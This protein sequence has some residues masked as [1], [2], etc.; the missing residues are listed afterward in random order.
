MLYRKTAHNADSGK[1]ALRQG[2]QEGRDNA[3]LTLEANQKR[4]T[5]DYRGMMLY[6]LLWRQG[7]ITRPDVTEQRQT[8]H[9]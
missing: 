3:D 7:M 4:L 8:R 2:W 1:N 9:R 6:A 5:R